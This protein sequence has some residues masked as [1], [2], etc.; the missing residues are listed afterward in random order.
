MGMFVLELPSSISYRI[1]VRK[2]GRD[3]KGLTLESLDIF[4]FL[5]ILNFLNGRWVG[6]GGGG[7]VVFVE[8]VCYVLFYFV[9]RLSN[10]MAFNGLLDEMVG[11]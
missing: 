6:S 4:E 8:E 11:F 2:N 10:V 3:Y 7:G 5:E 9:N 1:I